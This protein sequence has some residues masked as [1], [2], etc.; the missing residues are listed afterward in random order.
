VLLVAAALEQAS[1]RPPEAGEVRIAL[2][3][4]ASRVDQSA[5]RRGE[6]ADEADGDAE[7]RGHVGDDVG[8]LDDAPKDEA[9]KHNT[10]HG[11]RDEY[12]ACL[13]D[14]RA[15]QQQ[16]SAAEDHHS[17][18]RERLP[19]GGFGRALGALDVVSGQ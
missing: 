6:G 5:E 16:H 1:R 2:D 15:E 7:L 13:A 12:G 8:R 11:P 19:C 14:E 17:Q 10:E 18:P 4:L 3:H 9:A